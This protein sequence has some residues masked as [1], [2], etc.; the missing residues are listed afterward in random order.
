MI[1]KSLTLIG[2]G[3]MV[4]SYII[5]TA[6]ISTKY[7]GRVEVISSQGI[8]YFWMWE[9]PNFHS[10]ENLY[11]ICAGM[12]SSE[13]NQIWEVEL[14]RKDMPTASY[15]FNSEKD[16]ENFAER[17]CPTKNKQWEIAK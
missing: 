13:N 17:F 11:N 2:I 12:Y 5:F 7:C 14:D 9:H 8:G 4:L 10:E 6:A 16:A 3:I 15:D 1:N